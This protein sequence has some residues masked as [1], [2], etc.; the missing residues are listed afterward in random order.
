MDASTHRNDGTLGDDYWG[1]HSSHSLEDWRYEVQS[2]DT[3]LGYW[4][5][6]KVQ[7]DQQEHGE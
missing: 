7:I 4:D 2:D 6:V 5:W 1:E 3:R